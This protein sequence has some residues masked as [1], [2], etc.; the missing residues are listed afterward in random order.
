MNQNNYELSS[1]YIYFGTMPEKSNIISYEDLEL[2]LYYL[3]Y[4]FEPN[5]CYRNAHLISSVI[6]EIKY[7]EGD[8]IL[9]DIPIPITHAWNSY[10]GLE[11]DIT[12]EL[13]D[14]L[15]NFEYYKFIEGTIEELEKEYIVNSNIDLFTQFLNKSE[16]RKI[17]ESKTDT[18]YS[19]LRNKTL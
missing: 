2:D 9:K 19:K 13:F 11:F 18:I 7:I 4:L 3:V 1:H 5:R 12:F 17:I 8:V 15:N 16:N 10:D 6:P 14:N